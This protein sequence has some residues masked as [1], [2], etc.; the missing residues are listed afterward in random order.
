[1]DRDLPPRLDGHFSFFHF[2]QF[3][4]IGLF[5]RE[6]LPCDTRAPFINMPAAPKQRKIAIV[7][8]RSVGLSP[9]PSLVSA[10]PIV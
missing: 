4:R 10:F 9:L 7:G 2:L 6:I 3:P 1:M 5:I 8:S